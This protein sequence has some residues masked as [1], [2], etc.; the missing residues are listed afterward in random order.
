MALVLANVSYRVLVSS[1]RRVFAV[2]VWLMPRKAIL[3]RLMSRVVICR[4][5]VLEYA[6]KIIIIVICRLYRLVRLVVCRMERR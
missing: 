5:A 3:S 4:V 2:W 1:N 6:L